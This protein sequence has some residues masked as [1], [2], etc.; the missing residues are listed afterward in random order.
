[1]GCTIPCKEQAGNREGKPAVI[2]YSCWLVLAWL[3]S[4]KMTVGFVGQMRGAPALMLRSIAAQ[5]GAQTAPTAAAALRCVS[6]HEGHVVA[7][8]SF[9]TRARSFDFAEPLEHARSSG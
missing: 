6:K 5:M 1:M 3:R 8:S 7:S 4:A 9:E 2:S